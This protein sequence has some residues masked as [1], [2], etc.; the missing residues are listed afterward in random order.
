MPNSAHNI[1]A[2]QSNTPGTAP[3]NPQS[4]QDIGGFW[5]TLMTFFANNPNFIPNNNPGQPGIPPP[6]Y[7]APQNPLAAGISL[8]TVILAV[9]VIVAVIVTVKLIK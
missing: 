9:L 5:Q 8:N 7:S 6:Q 2:T 3:I 1:M 4:G